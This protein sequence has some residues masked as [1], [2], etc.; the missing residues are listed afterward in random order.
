MSRRPEE[1]T[2]RGSTEMPCALRPRASSRLEVGNEA[3]DAFLVRRRDESLLAE[4]ALPLGRLPL[5]QVLLP[6]LGARQ[7]AGSGGP[8]PLGGAPLRLDLRHG[9]AV[10]LRRVLA[11]LGGED[12]DHVPPL[13]PRVALNRRDIQHVLCHAIQ[14]P[15]AELGMNHLPPAEPDRDLGLV[16]VL[17][18]TP[19]VSRLELKVVL[20][21]LRAHLHF[22]D[23]DD[24]LL[25]TGVLRAAA[26]LVLELPEVHDP[27]DR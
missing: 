11:L 17:E 15:A 27:A 4:L 22:L 6:P 3:P 16:P 12:H 23:L 9:V 20:V 10:S 25:L 18:K 2:T 19:D 8:D 14:Q 5:E 24:C 1:C 26:L 13:Q 21:R 7:L